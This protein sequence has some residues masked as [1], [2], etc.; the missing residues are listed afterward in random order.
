MDPKRPARKAAGLIDLVHPHNFLSAMRDAGYRGPAQAVAEFIDN[1]LEAGADWIRVTV[2]KHSEPHAGVRIA[3]IDNGSG[4][5]PRQLSEA[6]SFGGSSRFDSRTSYGRFGMGLPSASLSLARRVDVK[7]WRGSSLHEATLQVGSGTAGPRSTVRTRRRPGAEAL[8]TASG[9]EVTLHECDRVPYERVGW[10][11]RSLVAHFGRTY[12]SDLRRGLRLEVNGEVVPPLEHLQLDSGGATY[13]DVLTYQLEGVGGHGRVTV[14]FSELPV[15][16]WAALSSAERAKRG[17]PT[18]NPISVS[19]AGREIER[20]WWFMGTKRRENYDSWWRCQIDFEPSLD[21]WFGITFT[22]QQI[23]PTQALVDVLSPDLEAIARSLNSRA[24][25]QFELVK[26]ADPLKVAEQIARVALEAWP[27]GFASATQAGELTLELSDL[28]SVDAYEVRRRN[29]GVVLVLNAGHPFVRDLYAPL[30]A[31]DTADSHRA[32]TQVVLLAVAQA[33]VGAG[34][35]DN[36]V[37]QRGWSDFVA[38][39][40][41]RCR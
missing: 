22:K 1:A 19:R 20:G 12:S 6:L 8:S 34:P 10:L 25:R 17:I 4:M 3:V 14:E 28:V 2:S 23:R 30:A 35:A 13:G 31:V 21:E 16:D 33:A 38:T 15:L 37:A 40:L 26:I 41:E 29:N 9:T 11:V 27:N 5:S 7:T 24:R 18:N 36:S 39:L 32:A